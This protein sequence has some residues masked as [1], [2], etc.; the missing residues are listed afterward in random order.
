MVGDLGKLGLGVFIIAFWLALPIFLII[1]GVS[2]FETL[3]TT[4]KTT[5]T[6]S[7]LNLVGLYFKTAVINIKGVSIYI[8]LFINV[9]QIASLLVAFLLFRGD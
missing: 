4:T 9:L 2:G 1:L 5:G 3:D 8:Q 7:I 6:S